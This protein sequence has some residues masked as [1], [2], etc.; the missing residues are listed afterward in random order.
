MNT[1][2]TVHTR[3]SLA[4]ATTR[5]QA[6]SHSCSLPIYMYISEAMLLSSYVHGPQP[7]QSD[8]LCFTLDTVKPEKC[9]RSKNF[10]LTT[11]KLVLQA[12]IIENQIHQRKYWLTVMQ[13]KWIHKKQKIPDWPSVMRD[14]GSLRKKSFNKLLT[15]FTSCHLS[16]SAQSVTGSYRHSAAAASVLHQ[17]HCKH[18]HRS[19]KI[20]SK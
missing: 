11:N 16:L 12:I 19:Y 14:S 2:Q 10:N 5:H 15:T 1:T 6:L 8:N 17:I 3:Q 4:T 18:L 20:S 9:L 13:I 7:W